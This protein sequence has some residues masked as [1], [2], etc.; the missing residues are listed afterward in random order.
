MWAIGTSKKKIGI[1]SV[2]FRLNGMNN[3][4]FI[5][6]RN[7]LRIHTHTPHIHMTYGNGGLV[8]TKNFY[9]DIIRLVAIV[10]NWPLHG[11]DKIIC[12]DTAD[13]ATQSAE[14]FNCD[15]CILS[16]RF[17]CDISS[18]Y[19][20]NHIHTRSTHIH[21]LINNDDL[22]LMRASAIQYVTSVRFCYIHQKLIR[23]PECSSSNRIQYSFRSRIKRECL[24]LIQST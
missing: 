24:S 16:F 23:S 6:W 21:F 20:Q 9:V 18:P 17:Y 14:W 3:I 12:R 15:E 22:H 10:I 2:I 1:S 7:Q 13:N 8:Y 19:T 5:K 11:R 4:L